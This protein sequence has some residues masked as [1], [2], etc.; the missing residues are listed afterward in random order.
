MNSSNFKP[1]HFIGEQIQVEFDEPPKF[2][3]KP[4]C[5][6]RFIWKDH[7]YQ[8]REKL[9][10]WYDFSRKGKM[11]FN[12]RPEHLKTAELKGSWGVGRIYFRVRTDSEQI[13]ELYYDRAPKNVQDRKGSWFLFKELE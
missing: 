4:G 7:T 13:F 3:K 12:M 8:I 1:I 10:E 6:D 2:D 9:N 11:G 5:P